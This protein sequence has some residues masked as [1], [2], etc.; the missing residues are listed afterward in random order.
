MSYV[1]ILYTDTHNGPWSART[2]CDRIAKDMQVRRTHV[3]QHASKKKC[4]EDAVA[5]SLLWKR[6]LKASHDRHLRSHSVNLHILTSMASFLAIILPSF[7]FELSACN[8][9]TQ[10]T[11]RINGWRGDSIVWICYCFSAKSK[12]NTLEVRYFSSFA[13]SPWVLSLRS[14]VRPTTEANDPF[15][16][17]SS[18][19]NMCH[20]CLS[21]RKITFV[22]SWMLGTCL[23]DL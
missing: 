18:N 14:F 6:K 8:L 10:Y 5:R 15:L 11:H 20:L 22:F 13:N 19:A 23:N 4:H 21:K 7:Y 17:H 9:G 12:A 16:L 3:V 1:C 2:N